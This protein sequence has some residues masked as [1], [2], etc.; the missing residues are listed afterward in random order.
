MAAEMNTQVA[1]LH[2]TASSKIFSQR[3]TNNGVIDMH[4]LHPTEC[5]T[6]LKSALNNLKTSGYNGRVLVVTGT[7]HH[8]RKGAKSIYPVI[9]EYLI[10]NNFKPKDATMSDGRGG[11]FSFLI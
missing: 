9:K 5:I 2:S 8:S 3:N 10:N 6:H 7:G 1:N 11:V 4:G